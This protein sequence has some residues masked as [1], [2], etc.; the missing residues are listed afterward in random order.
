LLSEK[1]QAFQIWFFKISKKIFSLVVAKKK[2]EDFFPEFF[3]IQKR[4]IL[5]T[6]ILYEEKLNINFYYE[7]N[8]K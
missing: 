1:Y 8:T 6:E 4:N 3:F 7:K 5:F 2:F